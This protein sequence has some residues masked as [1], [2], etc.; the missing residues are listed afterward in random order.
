MSKRLK[1]EAFPVG[2]RVKSHYNAP[3]TGVIIVSGKDYEFVPASSPFD[4]KYTVY[5]NICV[6]HDGGI[7]TPV[8]VEGSY[9][10]MVHPKGKLWGQ[11]FSPTSVL[12]KLTH[13]QY[14]EPMKAQYLTLDSSW[15]NE[16][17][18]CGCK[19]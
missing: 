11:L 5:H 18:A 8:S 17:K 19:V 2:T 3:W 9:C 12:I 6:D 15:L 14:G 10:R 4:K 13:N 7:F 1:G 16:V